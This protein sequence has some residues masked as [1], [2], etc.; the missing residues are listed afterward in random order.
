MQLSCYEKIA[1]HFFLILLI[2]YLLALPSMVALAPRDHVLLRQ[3]NGKGVCFM[4]KGRGF[5]V[6]KPLT[7]KMRWF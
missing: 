5:C 2:E 3:G 4:H 7:N 6:N 1:E